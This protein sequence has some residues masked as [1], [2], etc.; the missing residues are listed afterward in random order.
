MDQQPQ[1]NQ[2]QNQLHS[3][4]L[5]LDQRQ[6]QNQKL[7]CPPRLLLLAA[8]YHC[9]LNVE[10]ESIFIPFFLNF[11]LFYIAILFAFF[12]QVRVGLGELI[13]VQVPSVWLQINGIVNAY[14]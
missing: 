8:S 7:K 12:F 3:L 2:Q 11:T 14:Q 10:V 6:Q 5:N 9:G 13:V 1:R 4:Q